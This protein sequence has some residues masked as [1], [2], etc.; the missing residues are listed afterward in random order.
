MTRTGN[1]T[2]AFWKRRGWH[3]QP[4]RRSAELA[5]GLGTTESAVRMDIDQLYAS[6]LMLDGLDEGHPPMLLTAGR[7]FLARGGDVDREVL[8]FLPRTID[9]LNACEALLV[10][11]T[12]LVDEFRIALPRGDSVEHA[13]QLVPAGFTAAVDERLALDLF[14][15]TAALMARLSNGEPAGCVAEEVISLA[16]IEEAR[17]WLEMRRE[18]GELDEAEERAAGEELRGLFELFEDD[19]V[20]NMFEMAEPA[21][22][23]LAGQDPINQQLGVADQRVEAW[24]YSFGGTSRR[25]TSETGLTCRRT[26][27]LAWLC[28][29]RPGQ[30]RWTASSQGSVTRPSSTHHRLRRRLAGDVPLPRPART[31]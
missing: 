2:C 11:G 6:G 28:V 25:V 9:D 7:Q 18:E 17:A 10:A 13:Q 19:D 31:R 3:R 22:A 27:E 29:T 15:A 12:V 1:A 26:P 16:L 5:R 24:F 30:S 4:T 8:A 14:A 21:D 23:A 20:L